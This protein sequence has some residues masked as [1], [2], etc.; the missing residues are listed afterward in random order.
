MDYLY[1]LQCLRESAPSFV[2]IFFLF[3]SEFILIGGFLIPLIIY[4]CLDKSYGATILLGYASS[5]FVNQ[6]IKNTACIY[7][8]WIRDSRLYIFPAAESSASGYSF[9]SGHT[10]AAASV[11]GGLAAYGKKRKFFI[12]LMGLSTL[13]TAFSRNWLGAHTMADVLV[14]IINTC[15]VLVLIF[16]LKY[17]LQANPHK[18]IFIALIGLII[19][20]TSLIFLSLKAYPVDFLEDGKILV[21][22]YHMITGCY[23]SCGLLSG[24]LIAWIIERRFIKFEVEGSILCKIIRAIAGSLIILCM[25]IS[26]TDILSFMGEHWSHLVKYFLMAVVALA[27]YPAAFKLFENMIKKGKK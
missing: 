8:P 17:Y 10:T 18:D 1:I 25:Q 12:V 23:T 13:L 26:L 2:N 6:F 16:I 27:V 5:N 11:Y 9:P 24:A 7:R 3:V 15:L 22:P 21:D 20:I 14:A 4:W 19:S